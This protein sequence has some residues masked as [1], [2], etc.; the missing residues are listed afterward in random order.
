MMGNYEWPSQR[1][2]V[3][4]YSLPR[5]LLAYDEILSRF[6]V[7]VGSWVF[8]LNC[9]DTLLVSTVVHHSWNS[10]KPR[11]VGKKISMTFLMTFTE[12]NS[13]ELV[14]TQTSYCISADEL[15]N[16]IM[17]YDWRLAIAG[18]CGLVWA[19]IFR[20]GWNRY[21]RNGDEGLEVMV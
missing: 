6:A 16:E 2:S 7:L 17:I 1:D 19:A 21:W 8:L 14:T 3:Q 13:G 15:F 20:Q 18:R 5:H 4:F 12:R 10:N 9:E 11:L